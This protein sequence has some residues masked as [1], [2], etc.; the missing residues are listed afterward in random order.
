MAR[1]SEGPHPR[2]VTGLGVGRRRAATIVAAIAVAAS[3]PAAGAVADPHPS[4]HDLQKQVKKLNTKA[5]KATEAYNGGRVKL[6]KARGAAKRADRKLRSTN[7]E[8]SK[9]ERKVGLTAA[10]QYMSGGNGGEMAAVVGE[11]PQQVIDR[12]TIVSHLDRNQAALLGTLI[13][14]QKR[15]ARD[16]RD[17]RN[18][19]RDAKRT[20]KR[21][22][23]QKN[24]ALHAVNKVKSKLRDLRREAAARN[25]PDPTKP[26]PPSSTPPPPSSGGSGKAAQAVSAAESQ[27]G[28]PYVWGA[29]GPSS[30]DCSGLTMWAYNKV[31]ISLPHYTVSQYQAAKSHPSYSQAQPGDLIFFGSDMH[32]VGMYV[33]GGKMVEAPHTGANV[34]ISSVSARSSE[35]SGLGRYA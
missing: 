14:T 35:I 27:I 32:H 13:K 28:K 18:T 8:L 26:Q 19:A 22:G 5:E 1:D 10:Q 16:S 3:I 25:Q 24:D 20:A 4:M 2:R 11:G 9:L 23:G 15:A 12:S 21:L 30:Y 33:G 34:R 6:R 31:G 7:R 29:A 17:A